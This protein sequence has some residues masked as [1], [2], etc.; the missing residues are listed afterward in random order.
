[1]SR[2]RERKMKG[3]RQLIGIAVAGAV[4][5]AVAL[6]SGASAILLGEWLGEIKGDE[7][8]FVTFNVEKNDA[9]KKR[10]TD[11]MFG[12][13]DITCEGG[14]KDEADGVSLVG[15]F[16]VRHGEFGRKADAVISGLD[17]PANLTGKFK[18][19][20]RAVGTIRARGELDPND[21]PDLRCRSGLQE[22]KA[23]KQPPPL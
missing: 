6:P 21:H 2:Q 16:R 15:G 9:G 18:P 8:S 1:M 22:W 3:R 20:K 4:G 14:V 13:L 7:D 12:G 17:P 11:V 10:V 19:R 23:K 5:V